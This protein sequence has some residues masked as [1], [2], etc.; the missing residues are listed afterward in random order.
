MLSSKKGSTKTLAVSA[1]NTNNIANKTSRSST[2]KSLPKK[3][4]TIAGST[5]SL[6]KKSK[7]K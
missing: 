1:A 2:S 4:E 3:K 7:D 6:G 5:T